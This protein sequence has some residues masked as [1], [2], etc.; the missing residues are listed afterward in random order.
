MSSF[1]PAKQPFPIWRGSTFHYRFQ[2]LNDN[3]HETSPQD[4]TAFT[5]TLPIRSPDKSEEYFT[6]TDGNGGIV[7]NGTSGLIDIIIP[8]STTKGI[9]WKQA[10]Y[11]LLV[12]NPSTNETLP[13]LTGRF[14]VVN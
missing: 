5:G 8:A 11:E 1:L 9:G 2:W 14:R 7:F 6:L 3:G 4:L 12:V 10:S 13:L